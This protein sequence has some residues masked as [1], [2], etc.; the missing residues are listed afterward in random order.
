MEGDP[1]ETDPDAYRV[2]FEN[3]RV[4][5]ETD[6]HA[7]FVELKAPGGRPPTRASRAGAVEE[8][9]GPEL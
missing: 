3:D 9:V 2:M 5:G 8:A 6:S 4:R 7:I 1:A